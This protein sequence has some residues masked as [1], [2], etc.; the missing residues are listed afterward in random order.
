M[1]P[2]GYMAAAEWV[3][4]GNGKYWIQSNGIMVKNEWLELEGALYYF[5]D[6]GCVARDE[7]VTYPDGT[8][9]WADSD[10]RISKIV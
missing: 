2:N 6:N 4:D 9:G 5:K 8:Q 10:G 7:A 1:K 3:E